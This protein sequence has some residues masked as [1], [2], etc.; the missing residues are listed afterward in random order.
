MSVKKSTFEM[1]I[2]GNS[3]LKLTF[4]TESKIWLTLFVGLYTNENLWKS[5][6]ILEYDLKSNCKKILQRTNVSHYF[7]SYKIKSNFSYACLKRVPSCL[8]C[9]SYLLFLVLVMSDIWPW[10]FNN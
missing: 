1:L 6:C 5:G 7:L 9:V 2:T 4:M 8:I 3:V 10:V